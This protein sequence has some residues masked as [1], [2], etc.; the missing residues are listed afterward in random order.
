MK[1]PLSTRLL[2]CCGF[3][4]PGALLLKTASAWTASPKEIVATLL[5]FSAGAV[6]ICE[7]S[8]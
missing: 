7:E 5:F 2:A 1:I 8:L 6:I 3:V 4:K